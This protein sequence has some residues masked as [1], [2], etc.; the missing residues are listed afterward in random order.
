[1]S[2]CLLLANLVVLNSN[3]IQ[4]TL[5]LEGPL[6]QLLDKLA[7]SRDR[8]I[9]FYIKTLSICALHSLA[10]NLTTV[11]TN[12]LLI[13]VLLGRGAKVLIRQHVRASQEGNTSIVTGLHHRDQTDILATDR[14]ILV[15]RFILTILSLP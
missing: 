13:T 7:V 15:G 14:G 1:M 5:L 4:S 12:L 8:S 11:R 9:F 6:G 2:G 10:E 3:D